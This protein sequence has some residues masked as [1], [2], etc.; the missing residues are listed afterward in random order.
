METIFKDRFAIPFVE[1]TIPNNKLITD[2]ILEVILTHIQSIKERQIEDDHILQNQWFMSDV[3]LNSSSK[4]S[5]DEWREKTIFDS[6]QT[7]F[8]I[9]IQPFNIRNDERMIEF[10][11][12]IFEVPN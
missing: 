7:L 11:K 8:E 2:E 6:I 5:W 1:L 12:V 10:F 9:A 4:D 3:S